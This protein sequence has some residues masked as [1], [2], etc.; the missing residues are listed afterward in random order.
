MVQQGHPMN[1]AF[2]LFVIFWCS[3]LQASLLSRFDFDLVETKAQYF[4][5]ITPDIISHLQ[6]NGFPELIHEPKINTARMDLEEFEI[7]E[8]FSKNLPVMV[9][10]AME[11]GQEMAREQLL[12]S[13]FTL[14]SVSNNSIPYGNIY[15]PKQLNRLVDELLSPKTNQ[16]DLMLFL[17]KAPT[18]FRALQ[19]VINYCDPQFR[20]SSIEQ[21][22]VLLKKI[23]P[24]MKKINS[25]LKLHIE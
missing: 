4:K 3:I 2:I 15:W 24:L 16:Q 13:S 17:F 12:N 5:R 23:P 1:K 22:M 14:S 20:E 9:K 18:Y 7:S 11:Y 25:V 21:R 6:L 8:Y 10:W 19:E